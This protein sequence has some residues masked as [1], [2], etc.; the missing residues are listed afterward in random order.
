MSPREN[1]CFI[2]CAKPKKKGKYAAVFRVV[3]G[4][5]FALSVPFCFGYLSKA[6]KMCTISNV[7]HSKRSRAWFGRITLLSYDSRSNNWKF[8]LYIQTSVMHTH[9]H[10]YVYI[11][12]HQNDSIIFLLRFSSKRRPSKQNKNSDQPPQKECVFFSQQLNSIQI[13]C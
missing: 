7:I 5:F 11:L 6:A 13:D 3:L 8:F 10:I 2:C 12:P 1:K 9:T 4:V